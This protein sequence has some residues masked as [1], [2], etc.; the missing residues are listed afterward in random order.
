MLD[1][2]MARTRGDAYA[3]Y[4]ARTSGLI[5][6]PPRKRVDVPVGGPVS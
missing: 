4:A 6:R 5:P 2:R 3:A 1:R